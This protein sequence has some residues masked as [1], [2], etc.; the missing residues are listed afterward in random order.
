M[1][2]LYVCYAAFGF[3]VARLL[4]KREPLPVNDPV[5]Q[6]RTSGLL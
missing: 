6:L 2:F 4:F 1:K 5:A 3:A